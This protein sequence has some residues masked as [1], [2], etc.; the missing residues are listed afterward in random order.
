[1]SKM[2]HAPA[3]MRFDWCCR[4]NRPSPGT[5]PPHD[6]CPL[7]GG[8]TGKTSCEKRFSSRCSPRR[9][10][11]RRRSPRPMATAT[12]VR[13]YRD[14][15]GINPVPRRAHRANPPRRTTPKVR[16]GAVRKDCRATNPDRP[17]DHRSS[18]RGP[19]Q[20]VV[21]VPADAD[22]AALFLLT[23]RAE[24]QPV[25]STRCLSTSI[26]LALSSALLRR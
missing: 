6:C 19:H 18:S 2:V 8:R 21:A 26:D 23:D 3:I 9:L 12:A 5:C 7:N 11:R 25:T 20:P 22:V 16:I 14:F 13:R 17:S 4:R 15:R 24:T 1:M 10:A